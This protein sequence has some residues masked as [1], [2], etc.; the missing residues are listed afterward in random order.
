MIKSMTGFGKNVVSLPNKSI[1]IEFRSVNSKNFDFIS[2]IPSQYREKEPQIRKLVQTILVRGKI[3][4]SINEVSGESNSSVQINNNA[5]KMHFKS[6]QET[7]LE[8]GITPNADMLSAILRIPDVL[9]PQVEDIDEKEW[10]TIMQGVETACLALDN[11]RQQEGLSLNKDFSERIENIR[12][13]QNEI[14]ALEEARVTHLRAKFE[15][16]L[17]DLIDRSNIDENRLEQE[18]IYY[19]EKLDITEEKVRLS[20][21]LDYFNEVLSEDLSQGKKLNFISQEI[22]RELNTLGSKANQ[23]QIQH[24]IVR[25]KDELE[26]IKEQLLNIL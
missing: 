22:G 17:S 4:L 19:M 15:K 10:Y 1:N 9:V 24:L 3:E 2:R 7:A 5:L 26:K 16:D 25:M 21:H 18:L 20:Q 6:M 8:L 11:F 23:A 13:Y 12:Q 14:P